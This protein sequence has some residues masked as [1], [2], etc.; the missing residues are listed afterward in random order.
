MGNYILG[1]DGRTP[2]KCDDVL[3]W[4]K[5]FNKEERTVQKTKIGNVEV[6]TVFLGIDHRFTEDGP[7]ILFET[8]IF[9]DKRFEDFQERYCTYDEAIAG[10]KEAIEYAAKT[11]NS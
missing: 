5:H 9:G 4:A 7:P 1:I 3:E 2:V 8:M 10:H 11:I 6:S